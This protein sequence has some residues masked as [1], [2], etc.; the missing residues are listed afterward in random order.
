MVS[1][2]TGLDF[3]PADPAGSVDIPLR[4]P[5]LLWV[6][7]LADASFCAALGQHAKPGTGNRSGCPQPD[8]L[9]PSPKYGPGLSPDRHLG[10]DREPKSLPGRGCT[11]AGRVEH[12]GTETQLDVLSVGL[13]LTAGAVRRHV[14][15]EAQRSRR[16]IIQPRKAAG[17]SPTT[18][19]RGAG[20]GSRGQ[21]SWADGT[22]W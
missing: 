12:V 13:R 16:V 19:S 1:H 22:A 8:P 18:R 10:P 11:G 20:P 5:V 9:H 4:S 6:R 3:P 17:R 7:L 21:P 2:A 15:V 14:Q